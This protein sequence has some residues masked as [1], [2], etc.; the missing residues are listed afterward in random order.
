MLFPIE[1]SI[2]GYRADIGK[3][4]VGKYIYKIKVKNEFGFEN[5]VDG[6]FTVQDADISVQ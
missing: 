3:L 6:N 2:N 5:S 1:D 4:P